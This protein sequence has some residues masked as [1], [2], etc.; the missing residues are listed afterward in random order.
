[1]IYL[2]GRRQDVDALVFSPDGKSLAVG[3]TAS[4]VQLWHLETRT[5]RKVLGPKGPH[6]AV[7]FLP[8]GR[9]MT[10]TAAPEIRVGPLEGEGPLFEYHGPPD[11]GQKGYI[12]AAATADGG[13]IVACGQHNYAAMLECVALPDLAYR[14]RKTGREA[15]GFQP[16][17]LCPC[18]DG[19]MV[20][21]S[22]HGTALFD[23]ATG[24]KVLGLG[25][26]LQFV[27][28][29]AVSRDG[30]LVAVAAG[31]DLSLS[32]LA[33]GVRT[34]SVHVAGRKQFTARFKG[35]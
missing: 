31:M 35:G 20:V 25:G 13:L 28:A 27:P 12:H 23:S 8:G 32:R 18:P 10:A 17:R 11:G 24:E 16:Y 3:G 2:E 7:A 4:H 19:R 15:V 30:L 34:A 1:M 21:A 26:H 14:W 5:V 9:I 22:D 6:R 29:V 33:D